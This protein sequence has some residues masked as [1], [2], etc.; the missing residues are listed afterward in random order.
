M[1]QTYRIVCNPQYCRVLLDRFNRQRSIWARPLFQCVLMPLLPF[2]A[3]SDA[4][5]TASDLRAA[6]GWMT[7]LFIGI[8]VLVYVLA[9]S[10][11]LKRLNRRDLAG[12]EIGYSLSVEGVSVVGPSAQGRMDWS[13]YP[14]A[15]RF[16]DGIMLL[17]RGVIC[18][19]PDIALQ[20]GSPAEAT[21]LVSAHTH[22]RHVA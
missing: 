10:I 21:E 7:L 5:R 4:K 6:F 1:I 15:V 8:A 3:W 16:S 18:W 11:I 17:R 20:S 9:P 13:V 12:K 14:H 19:L 2:L 22:L